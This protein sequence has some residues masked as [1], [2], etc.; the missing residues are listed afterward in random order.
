MAN[1][2]YVEQDW[3]TISIA[4]NYEVSRA[5]DVR[6]RVADRTRN[7]AGQMLSK[8]FVGKYIFYALRHNNVVVR[9]S[10]HRLVCTAFNGERP[11]DKRH[12]AHRDGNSHNNIPENLYW[13]TPKENAAD[14][15]RHGTLPYGAKN[16]SHTHP[17]RRA[18]GFRSGSYT[19][20]ERR[21]TGIRNG[22]HT[23]PESIV[24]GD[25]HHTRRDPSCVQ[26]GEAN[27]G[28]GKLTADQVRHIRSIEDRP[29]VCLDLGIIYGVTGTMI[30]R[31][32]QRKSWA[33][34][35]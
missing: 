24:R 26:R 1:P 28:G 4:P 31:I 8:N 23:K 21:P 7:N 11:D 5:G 27:G 34:V 25:A 10:A 30:R 29:R 15:R 9:E 16:G 33:H 3:R 18:T 35:D 13:A 14:K 6:R 22:S 12:C 17:E 2:E 32:R 20:P 19:K